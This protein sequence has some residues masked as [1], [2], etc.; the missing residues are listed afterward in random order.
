MGNVAQPRFPQTLAFKPRV[1]D[2]IAQL[3]AFMFPSMPALILSSAGWP[4]SSGTLVTLGIKFC[5]GM[6]GFAGAYHF[7]QVL[8]PTGIDFNALLGALRRKSSF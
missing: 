4:I 5:A 2:E 3:V 8:N 7:S 1:S 6:A